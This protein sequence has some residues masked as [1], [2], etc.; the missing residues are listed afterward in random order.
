MASTP[1]TYKPFIQ[2]DR[3]Y[4]REVRLSDVNENY[5]RWMNDPDV[6]D[7]LEVRFF[8]NSIERIES[9]VRTMEEDP[10][11]LFMAIILKENDEHMGNIKLG[12]INWIHRF[13]DLSLFIGE[14]KF[15][16]KGYAPEA[17]GLAVDHA[18]NTLNLQKV[19]AGVYANNMGSLRAFKKAKF[20][21]EGLRKHH[22][23]YRGHYVDEVCLAIVRPE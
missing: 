18:F 12:P 14:K 19:T 2:G 17:I 15:W 7:F 10:D 5:Y 8:P 11:S 6:I 21:K 22:R 13:A 23:F 20:L 16:G 3:I 9:Y 1:V 4:L